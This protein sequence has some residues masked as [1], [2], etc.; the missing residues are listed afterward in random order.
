MLG[1]DVSSKKTTKICECG[2]TALVSL[3]SINKKLCVDCL[4]YIPWYLDPGQQALFD[5]CSINDLD[6]VNPKNS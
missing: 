3:I 2:S 6:P 1:T 4:R 5:S